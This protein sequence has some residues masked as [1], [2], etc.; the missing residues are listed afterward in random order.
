M[1]YKVVLVHTEEGYSVSIPSLPG[2]ASQGETAQE[3]MDNI[4]DALKDYLEVIQVS[5]P[6]RLGSFCNPAKTASMS[7]STS[8]M[9]V[10]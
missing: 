7:S 6:M 4:Q 3:A 1:T 8:V 5:R 9:L 2:C 10:T